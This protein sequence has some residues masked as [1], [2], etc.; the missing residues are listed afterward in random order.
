MS[1]GPDGGAQ[2]A[3]DLAQRAVADVVAVG[4][5]DVLEV[6]E[7]HDEQRDLG[8]EPVGAGEL[9]RQVHEHEPRVRQA[10]ERIGQRIFLRLFED[11]RVVDDGGGLLRNAI[12]QPAVIVGVAPTA[13]CGTRQ[14]VPMKRSLKSSGQ[15][16]AECSDVSSDGWPAAS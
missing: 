10:G 5:V 4:V 13:R 6:V 8:L 9:A 1:Y 11:D 2:H 15:T 12:E 7:V 3:G 16:S 14:I